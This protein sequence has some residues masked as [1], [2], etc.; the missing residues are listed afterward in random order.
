MGKT[1]YIIRHGIAADRGLYA[2]DGDRP[3]TEAGRAKTTAIARRLVSLDLTVDCILTSPLLR[4]QQTAQILQDA[5]LS[6]RLE[7]WPHLAP[8]GSLPAALAELSDRPE[9]TLAL[10]GHEPDLGEWVETLVWG[11]PKQHLVVKKAGV[12]GVQL[13]DAGSA[14]GESQLFWLTPPRFLLG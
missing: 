8:G 14:M 9:S 12:L 4:A 11:A 1:L 6:D 7:P 2:Q 5:G 10:V 3:L 13:P